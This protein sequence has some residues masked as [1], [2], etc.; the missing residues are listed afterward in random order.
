MTE[1][2][3]SKGLGKTNKHR[4]RMCCA[5]H[6]ILHSADFTSRTKHCL[7]HTENYTVYNIT[8]TR[9]TICYLLNTARYILHTT[10]GT[11]DTTHYILHN[12]HYI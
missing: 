9:N 5:A 4:A 7:D 1:G 8:Y 6:S 3:P 2:D 11:L 10:Y 12:A